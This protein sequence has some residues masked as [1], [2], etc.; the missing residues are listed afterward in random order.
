[1]LFDNLQGILNGFVPN[2][3]F[4]LNSDTYF[5]TMSLSNYSLAHNN[6]AH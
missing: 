5:P 2:I 3:Y 6:Q 4:L 1:M